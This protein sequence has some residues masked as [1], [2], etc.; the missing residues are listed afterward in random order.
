MVE[1]KITGK[2]LEFVNALKSAFDG[3]DGRSKVIKEL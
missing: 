2:K 3:L 1:S